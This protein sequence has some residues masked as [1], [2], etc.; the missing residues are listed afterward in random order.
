MGVPSTTRTR[1]R[2]RVSVVIP[3]FNYGHF[4]AEA[5]ESVLA[6]SQPA[7]E[8]IIVDDGSTDDSR[9]VAR[10]LIA[11]HPS[12]PIQLICQNN[13]GSPGITRNAG[14]ERATGEYILCLD[15]DDRLGPDYLMLCAAA[16]DDNPSAAIA[17][18]NYRTFG[19]EE[20]LVEAPPWDA[21]RELEGNFIP[22]ASMFRREAWEQAGGYG[23]WVSHED[24]DLWVGC[25]ERGWQG[26]HVEGAMWFYR[27][28]SSGIYLTNLHRDQEHKARLVSKHPSLYNSE[29]QR[30][31]AGVL[32]GD[33]QALCAGRAKGQIPPFHLTSP[34]VTRDRDLPLR[35]VCLI[36]KDYPPVVPGGVPRAVQMQA[37][38]LAAAGVEVHVITRSV[39]GVAGVREE[40]GVLVHEVVEPTFRVP[41]ALYYLEISGWAVVAA[42]KFIELDAHLGFDVVETP[43]YRG[44]ALHLAPRPETALIVW[45]HS[46]MMAYWNATPSYTRTPGDDVWHSLEMAALERAELLLGPSQL[47]IDTT[48]GFL[49]DR[50]RPAELMPYLFDPGQ[51]PFTPR[52]AHRGPVRALFYG[53]LEEL[54]NPGLALRAVAAARASG[55]DVQLTLL[56][57]DNWEYRQRELAPLQAELGLEDAIYR[58][59]TDIAG[60]RAILAETDVAILPSRFEVGPMTVLESLS[61]G[62]PVITS[63]RVGAASWFGRED[64]LMTIP[65]DDPDE[66]AASAAAAMADENFMASGPRAAA[67]LREQFSPESVTDRLLECYGRL[68]AVRGRPPVP[69][70]SPVHTRADANP[71]SVSD[72]E[73]APLVRIPGTRDVAVLAFADEV[74]ADPALLSA[75]A[76]EFDARDDVTLVIFAPGWSEEQ[77]MSRLGPAVAAAGLEPD[78]AADL[79]ALALPVSEQADARLA[80]GCKAILTRQPQKPPFDTHPTVDDA[81][82]ASLRTALGLERSPA[83]ARAL[84]GA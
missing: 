59:H 75:W 28:Q 1:A 22:T 38:R 34:R 64:G 53:R 19:E 62:V 56:G 10:A 21:R 9:D 2:S 23:P 60:V 73:P 46:T 72:R 15:A 63:N 6:Q 66:F 33:A 79:L 35:R 32:A 61:S 14:I 57:R 8:V 83:A 41:P 69:A 52:A 37:Q 80:G 81:S 76:R 24:W 12:A 29:Q 11:K 27:V 68:M 31:A 39:S 44:E 55:L 45:L 43:D 3:C 54:K 74:T 26:V 67:R 40:D 13:C 36:C 70:A 47:V 78:D 48:A 17:Y 25:I 5:L 18:S 84:P 71:D 7:D 65:I 82:V 20:T 50:M 4:L 42:S 49:G 51:F 30:W 77:A 58:S 16:L